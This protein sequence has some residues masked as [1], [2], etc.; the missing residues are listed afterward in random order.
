MCNRCS[1]PSCFHSPGIAVTTHE[2]VSP[3][4]AHAIPP[5]SAPA[6]SVWAGP[7]DEAHARTPS[8]SPSTSSR[9]RCHKRGR[10]SFAHRTF[11]P[12]RSP[13]RKLDT[14]SHLPLRQLRALRCQPIEWLLPHRPA[15]SVRCLRRCC[16]YGLGKEATDGRSWTPPSPHEPRPLCSQPQ[17]AST[18]RSRVRSMRSCTPRSSHMPRERRSSRQCICH[19]V[20]RSACRAEA[21]QLGSGRT[22]R[23]TN[24]L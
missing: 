24:G 7:V 1:I 2:Q 10:H 21:S 4:P 12:V 5:P 20:L 19:R 15:A 23:K 13:L 3:G 16:V 6:R 9:P 22:S 14:E 17:S 11:S 18:S 8:T